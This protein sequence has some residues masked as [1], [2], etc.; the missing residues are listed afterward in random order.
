MQALL[1]NITATQKAVQAANENYRNI[2]GRQV[3]MKKLA[4]QRRVNAEK[5]YNE[6]LLAAEKA[7]I[8]DAEIGAAIDAAW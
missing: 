4:E 8:S 1:N 5:L 6:A 2:D 7:G 3:T